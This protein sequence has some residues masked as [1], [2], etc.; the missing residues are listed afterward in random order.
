M[1]KI[2]FQGSRLTSD[3]GLILRLGEQRMA[4]WLILNE[5]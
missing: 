5:I 1:R 3:G 2:D 4:L